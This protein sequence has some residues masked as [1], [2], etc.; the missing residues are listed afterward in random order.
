MCTTIG[1]KREVFFYSSVILQYDPRNVCRKLC[2][3]DHLYTGIWKMCRVYLMLCHYKN[4][5][6]LLLTHE[7]SAFQIT[8]LCFHFP[9]MLILGRFSSF[10]ILWNAT[11][12]GVLHRAK[13]SR[14]LIIF[15]SKSWTLKFSS[16]PN[17]QS[18]Y[19]KSIVWFV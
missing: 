19:F 13:H 9:Q 7:L 17:F 8:R 5:K 2:S 11:E 18:L 14:N 10:G 15:S 12:V 6:H 16:F 3:T 4:Y 1:E